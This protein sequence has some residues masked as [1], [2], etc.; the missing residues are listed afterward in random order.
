MKVNDY[1]FKCRILLPPWSLLGSFLEH[2]N[3]KFGWKLEY[4]HKDIQRDLFHIRW[5]VNGSASISMYFSSSYFVLIQWTFDLVI[6]S[7]SM[8]RPEQKFR[9]IYSDF[10]LQVYIL[11]TI[12]KFQKSSKRS[13]KGRFLELI[14]NFAFGEIYLRLLNSQD[15]FYQYLVV[16]CSQCQKKWYLSFYQF[17]WNTP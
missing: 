15:T 4:I 17:E 13:V 14:K 11:L 2:I 3:G 6:R 5:D 1:S 9:T 10:L 16:K 12:I 8:L 7:V